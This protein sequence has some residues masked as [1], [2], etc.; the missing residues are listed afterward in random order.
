MSRRL[1]ALPSVWALA[2]KSGIEDLSKVKLSG[3]LLLLCAVILSGC[4]RRGGSIPYDVQNFSRPDT[5]R[6]QIADNGIIG[7][8]D[9]VAVQVFQ[10]PELNRD[11]QV[12]REGNIAMPLIGSIH[13]EGLTAQQLSDEIT[14][15][16]AAN[17]VRQPSVQVM[18]KSVVAKMLT[19]EGSVTRPGIFELRGQ[20]TLLGAMALAAGPNEFANIHR[21]VV[22][23]QI[24]GQRNAAAFDLE[25]IR[26]GEAEDP[27]IFGNDTVVVDGSKLN[28]AYRDILQA[29]PLLAVFRII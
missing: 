9:T 7:K 22:F 16:L 3:L 12:D 20:T 6:P 8:L 29:I 25:T 24:N 26:H 1:D 2:R 15:R 23:R 11:I 4:A 17:Y 18:I 13:A 10:L 21:V 5:E 14:H 28:R 27:A 19:V